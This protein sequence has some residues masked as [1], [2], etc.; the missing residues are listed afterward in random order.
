MKRPRDY[1]ADVTKGAIRLARTFSNIVSPPVIFAVLGLA[2][3]W[4]ELGFWPG[5]FWATVFGF[6]VS[7]APILL[8]VYLLRTGRITD[9][10][11]NTAQ[12]RRLPYL[13]SAVG[14]LVAL[15]L[16]AVF[17]GPEL[18]RC[19]AIYSLISVVIL[20]L[21]NVAWLISI[22]MTSI[23]AATLISGLVFGPIV[24]LALVPLAALVFLARLF[25]RRHTIPQLLAGALVGIVCVLVVM[26]LGCF[27]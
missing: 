15:I 27:D 21:I 20:G 19:L 7:L 22:H 6:W 1:S 25:L 13:S 14:A 9:L 5:L 10:H 8:V 26:V 3:A 11:M 12:E 17:S 2:L 4:Q 16:L 24:A 18:L 23:A